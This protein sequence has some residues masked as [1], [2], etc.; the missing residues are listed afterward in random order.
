MAATMP[1]VVVAEVRA[2]VVAVPVAAS[3]RVEVAV[4][5]VA[6][7]PSR[8]RVRVVVH[9]RMTPV[10]DRMRRHTVATVHR[11]DAV[12]ATPAEC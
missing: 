1:V 10:R 7:T 5:R 2:R 11:V 8:V 3:V 12:P 6:V 9:D 4:S